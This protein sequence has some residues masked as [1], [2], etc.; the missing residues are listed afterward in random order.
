MNTIS[1]ITQLFRVIIMELLKMTPLYESLILGP[2]R[3]SG[4][5]RY[6]SAV[7]LECPT[8]SIAVSS[9]PAQVDFVSGR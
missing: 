5:A 9:S 4:L 3:L 7:A 8:D 1:V 6:G 2:P